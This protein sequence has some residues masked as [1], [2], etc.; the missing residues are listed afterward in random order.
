MAFAAVSPQA[1]VGDT[2]LA[3]RG[4]LVSSLESSKMN[5]A[6]IA[7]ALTEHLF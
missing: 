6:R 7:T 2:I 4:P 5:G 1:E 3:L